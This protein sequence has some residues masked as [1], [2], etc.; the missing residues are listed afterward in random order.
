MIRSLVVVLALAVPARADTLFSAGL[1]A[2]VE[3]FRYQGPGDVDPAEIRLS[4]TG[5]GAAIPLRVTLT[6]DQRTPHALGVAIGFTPIIGGAT[7][8][9]TSMRSSIQ[10]EAL[11][12]VAVTRG[13]TWS[14]Q[15]GA[16]GVLQQPLGES[17][18]GI[19]SNDNV[20]AFTTL[21]GGI[22]AA[23]VTVFGANRDYTIDL[24]AGVLVADHLRAIPVML[25]ASA[26]WG[27]DRW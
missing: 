5:Y 14:V 16:G 1:G 4:T 17:S 20:Q 12:R 11:G 9:Q 10:L 24:R 19:L 13:D 22:V 8:G 6:Q 2:H 7:F 3:P 15:L 23:S 21:A 27:R 18:N 25:T 26:E